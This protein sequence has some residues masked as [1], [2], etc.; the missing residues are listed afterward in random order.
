[1]PTYL[2]A[3]QFDNLGEMDQFL[4]MQTTKTDSRMNRK[5]VDL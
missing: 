1:M 4:G 3:N 5:W 2:Y